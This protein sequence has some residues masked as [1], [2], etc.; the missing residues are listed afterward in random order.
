MPPGILASIET[1]RIRA[2]YLAGCN[3]WSTSRQRPL[4]QALGKLELLVVQDIFASELTAQAHVVLPGAA[5]AEKRGR[6]HGSR[7]AGQAS[8]PRRST[9]RGKPAPT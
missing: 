4:Q 9:L 8:S 2:L 3:R 5:G 7:R 6:R 1:G